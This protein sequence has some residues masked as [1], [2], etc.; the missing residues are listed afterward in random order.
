MNEERL[1][2]SRVADRLREI[3]RRVVDRK[4]QRPFPQPRGP[5]MA[6]KAEQK[7]G[8][9]TVTTGEENERTSS[10]FQSQVKKP[11]SAQ[12]AGCDALGIGCAEWKE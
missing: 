5:E 6:K 9:P 4:K 11:G 8:F 12:P 1:R 3:P 2:R 7:R 10:G